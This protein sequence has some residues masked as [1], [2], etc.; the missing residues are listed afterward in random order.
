M[1]NLGNRTKWRATK[2]K[3]G[4]PD[5]V[6]KFSLGEKLDAFA[7]VAAGVAAGDYAAEAEAWKTIVPLLTTYNTALAALKPAKFKGK[8]PAEQ[9][10]NSKKAKQEVS[11]ML[12]NAKDMQQRAEAFQKP[13]VMLSQAYKVCFAKFKTV[14]KDDK[15]ALAAFYS[16]EIRNDL[17]QYVKMAVKLPL[18]ALVLKDLQSYV[19][20]GDNINSLLNS[21]KP[22][23][24]AKIHMEMAK[25]FAVLGQHM[26]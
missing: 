23:D 15:P 14:K 2:E 25:C 17:G 5:N 9:D 18:G 10:A 8:T 19:K 26:N 24:T 4:I 11:E 16:K 13:M 21:K 1:N 12:K 7:K 6:S 3:Y 22:E 20:F